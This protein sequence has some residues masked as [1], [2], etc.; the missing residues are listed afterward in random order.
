MNMTSRREFLK[1]AGTVSACVCCFGTMSLLDSCASSKNISTTETNEIICVPAR[2]FGDQNFITIRSKKFEEP[3]FIS[4]QT[5]SSYVALRMLCT[6][7]GCTI[8]VAQDKQ[9]KLICPC[10]GSE[11]STQGIVLK[12]PAIKPLQSFRI[13]TESKSMIVHFN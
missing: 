13:T 10:H 8:K 1:Q 9:D 2:S 6:H 4:R 5:D 12:G 3:I 7:K 11:F